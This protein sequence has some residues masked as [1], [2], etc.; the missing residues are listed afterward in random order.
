MKSIFLA[1]GAVLS[2][3]IVCGAAAAAV[4]PNPCST[5]ITPALVQ[6]VTGVAVVRDTPT[7]KSHYTK[8]TGT[9]V[10]QF[11][12]AAAV[13]NAIEIGITRWPKGSKKGSSF[14]NL[15][16]KNGLQANTKSG[17]C[18]TSA[19]GTYIDALEP[20][21]TW[22]PITGQWKRGAVWANQL[23]IDL[24]DS[25]LFEMTGGTKPTNADGSGSKKHTFTYDQMIALANVTLKKVKH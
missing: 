19:Q 23:F 21:C 7:L 3:S 24:G 17:S 25:M 15:I 14:F 5:T 8:A 12:S 2:L 18:W 10:C 9:F 16:Q 4:P 6:Q 1:L 20:D 13:N 22:T 11:G